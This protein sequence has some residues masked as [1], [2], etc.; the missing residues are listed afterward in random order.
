MC[1][2][3]LCVTETGEDDRQCRYDVTGWRMD[4]VV[5]N[6]GR[7]S[8]G[9]WPCSGYRPAGVTNRSVDHRLG[10]W[11]YGKASASSDWSPSSLS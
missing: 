5:T 8:R 7:G 3:C 9:V 2:P 6:P 10:S 11:A 1:L 4:S